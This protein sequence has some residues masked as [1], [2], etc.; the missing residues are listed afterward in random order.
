M[1]AEVLECPVST[2]PVTDVASRKTQKDGGKSPNVKSFNV[3]V[4]VSVVPRIEA[5]AEAFGLD[6]TS[7]I[8]MVLLE[9]LSRY[10]QRAAQIREGKVP[11]E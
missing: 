5:T 9:N 8:R 1:F 10:E 11:D 6:E 2:P 4:N 3:R 7:F